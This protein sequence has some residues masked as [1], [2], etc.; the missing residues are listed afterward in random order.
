MILFHPEE[1]Q[2][3]HAVQAE[4]SEMR[5]IDSEQIE[6]LRSSI[7]P[8]LITEFSDEDVFKISRSDDNDVWET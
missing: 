4:S 8:G 6:G 1:Q 3:L 5:A 7:I 2:Y